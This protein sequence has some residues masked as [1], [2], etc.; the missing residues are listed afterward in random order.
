ME[1]NI[2]A[3][4]L[5]TFSNVISWG[6]VFIFTGQRKSEI[7]KYFILSLAINCAIWLINF[8]KNVLLIGV[9]FILNTWL[10]FLVIYL[11]REDFPIYHRSNHE[12]PYYYKTRKFWKFEN[13][14][15]NI[16]FVLFMILASALG[17]YFFIFLH[18]ILNFKN[19]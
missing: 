18:Q 1:L 16:S 8:E 7:C 15:I 10:F 3:P 14:L 19:N 2:L 12:F 5:I 11:K 9:L 6:T 4:A 17:F 13:S